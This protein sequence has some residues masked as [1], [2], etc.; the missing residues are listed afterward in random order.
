M[1]ITLIGH[2][3]LDVIHHPDGSTTQGYGGIFFSLA[4]LANL[5]PAGDTITPVFGVG[6]DDYDALIERLAAY[7]NVSTDAIYRFP[8]PTN[9]VHLFYENDGER[10][11][12]S[13]HISEPIPLKKIR[14]HCDADMILVNMISGFDITLETL[15]EIRMIVRDRQVPIYIDIHS[16]TLGIKEDFTRFH[17]PVEVWRRWLFMIH[18]AQMNE[19]EAAV[20]SPGKL[21]EATLAKHTLALNTK[22]LHIT[23]GERGCTTFVDEH[24]HLHRYDIG[25]IKV[26][27]AVDP[28][29]CGDVFAAAYCAH[30]MKSNDIFSSAQF[31]NRAAAMK[32]GMPGSEHIDALASLR[33]GAK[34]E[35]SIA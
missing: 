12:R 29:G 30:Y 22:V 19:E 5:L 10:V 18:A 6:K 2:L 23:R 20:L 31:A 32:A 16:V 14:P 4:T 3:C 26:E 27:G 35:E 24:K 25:G 17:R 11:E 13:E 21:D 33:L 7:P 9:Q 28:T 8:G 15:D 34:A 1:K